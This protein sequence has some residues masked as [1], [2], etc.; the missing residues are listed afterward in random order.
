MFND[1]EMSFEPSVQSAPGRR[2][3]GGGGAHGTL[4]WGRSLLSA[5]HDP[6]EAAERARERL[7][8]LRPHRSRP[9]GPDPDPKWEP[10]LHALL[11]DPW[12]CQERDGFER[13]WSDALASLERQGVQVGRGAYC[14]WDDADPGLARAA[15]CL[16]R[17]LR[18]Q[19][20]VETGVARGLT[21]SVVLQALQANGIGRLF[22]IDL[23]PSLDRGR[24]VD[25]TAAAVPDRVKPRWTPV[26]G[27]SRRRLPELLTRLGSIDL[28]IHDSCHSYRN[29][30]FELGL[31]WNALRPGGFMLADDV[32]RN[33][34]FGECAFRVR[35][36][37]CIVCAS[38]D[39][40]GLFGVI[41]KPRE[42]GRA[43]GRTPRPGTGR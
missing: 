33:S 41:Q 22:S 26:Q 38:D 39:G 27:S 10:S 13:L 21:T 29:M 11:A 40:K 28:F 17:H 42:A 16:T 4:R 43:V 32:H 37:P 2:R 15:W 30:R 1:S 12:P 18:P 8:D 20:V 5:T 24:F 9:A 19:T 25:Q 23:P 14:G 34:A 6:V 36:A 31:A 7:S 3:R 35:P